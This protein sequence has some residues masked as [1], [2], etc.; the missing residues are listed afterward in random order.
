LFAEIN[1]S[2]FKNISSYFSKTLFSK[3]RPS[4]DQEQLILTAVEAVQ[5]VC[6][7]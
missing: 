4:S 5:G 7:F 1:F 2:R 6:G 3:L